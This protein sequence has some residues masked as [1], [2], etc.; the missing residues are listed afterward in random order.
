MAE[1]QAQQVRLVSR[2]S[3][4]VLFA[5]VVP[6]RQVAEARLVGGLFDIHG[7][8]GDDAHGLIQQAMAKLDEDVQGRNDY[9]NMDGPLAVKWQYKTTLA[10]FRAICLVYGEGEWSVSSFTGTIM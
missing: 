6:A 8:S 1:E 7:K 10:H 9:E 5:A 2:I 4:L 3:R